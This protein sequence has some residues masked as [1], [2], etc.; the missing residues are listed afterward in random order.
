MS[1]F[2]NGLSDALPLMGVIA[3]M[4]I[5]FCAVFFYFNNASIKKSPVLTRHGKVIEKTPGTYERVIVEFDDKTRANLVDL[6]RKTI[7]TVGDTGVFKT[8]KHTIISFERD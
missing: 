6:K 1:D 4:S 5:V 8:Q 2:M 3:V 7:F